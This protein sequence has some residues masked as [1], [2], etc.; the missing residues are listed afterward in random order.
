MNSDGPAFD[1]PYLFTLSVWKSSDYNSL[2]NF[3]TI[4]ANYWRDIHRPDFDI[5]ILGK[6]KILLTQENEIALNFKT[7]DINDPDLFIEWEIESDIDPLGVYFTDFNSKM[8][9]SKGY[10][11]PDTNYSIKIFT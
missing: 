6:N 7:Y 5:E 8:I 3:T 2:A 10:L 1:E 11:Q 9:I 4:V